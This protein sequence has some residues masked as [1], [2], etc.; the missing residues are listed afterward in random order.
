MDG[1]ILRNDTG[2]DCPSDSTEERCN[3]T[4]R[5]DSFENGLNKFG[6]DEKDFAPNI[7]KASGCISFHNG[8]KDLPPQFFIEFIVILSFVP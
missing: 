5:T 3:F 6:T 7:K 8:Q 2:N 4:I 1:T